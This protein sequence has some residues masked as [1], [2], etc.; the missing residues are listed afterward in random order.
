MITV[1]IIGLGL[2]GGSMAKDLKSQL[3][4]RVLGVDNNVHNA[5]LAKELNLVD[6]IVP[7]EEALVKAQIILLAFPVDNIEILLPQVLD[8]IPNDTVVIDVGSTKEKICRG[9]TTHLKRGQYVAAHPLA[10]TEFS[11]PSAAISGLFRNKNNIICDKE[12]SNH[13]ALSK[14][15]NLFNSLGMKTSFLSSSEHDK[16]MAYVSHLSHLSSFTLSLTVLDIEKDESKI[17]NLASTGF[18]STARLAKSNPAT[19]TAIFEKN[20]NHLIE[21]I[22][23]YNS[24][25]M[26]FKEALIANDNKK[27]KSLMSSANDIKRVLNKNIHIDIN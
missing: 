22:D 18:E 24:Y 21:A 4:V 11:G 10:G 13:D 27:L 7:F 3:N 16:H 19:W 14:A 23:K 26:E 1:A 12:K 17:F 2:I 25:L 8:K 20:S 15:I 9:V 6:E 5:E